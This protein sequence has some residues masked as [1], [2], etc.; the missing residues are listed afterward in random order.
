[1]QVPGRPTWTNGYVRFSFADIDADPMLAR[2]PE[3]EM[4]DV[5]R[6]FGRSTR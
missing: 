2:D 6:E 5:L 1:M 3:H 4:L